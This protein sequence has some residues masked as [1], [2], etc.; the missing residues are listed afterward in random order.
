MQYNGKKKKTR[1]NN[2]PKTGTN[3]DPQN[4]REKTKD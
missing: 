1:T 2:D 4:I 3:N